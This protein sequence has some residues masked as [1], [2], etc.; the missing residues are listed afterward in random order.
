MN[1]EDPA[2]IISH[3]VTRAMRE[4]LDT[5]IVPILLKKGNEIR[6][7]GSGTCLRV[8]NKFFVITAGHVIEEVAS[9][10]RTMSLVGSGTPG[11]EITVVRR[12]GYTWDESSGV[13][14][15]Y[16]ELLGGKLT[17]LGK[18][19][20][21]VDDLEPNINHLQNDAISVWGYPAEFVRREQISERTALIVRPMHVQT[22][23][24]APDDWPSGKK[25][26]VHILLKYPQEG[27][28]RSGNP[29]P[30]P[31]APG[32]SGGSMWALGARNKD[33]WAPEKARMIGIQCSWHRRRRY[34]VGMQIQHCISKLVQDYPDL[35]EITRALREES[36]R[37]D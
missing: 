23:T 35:E 24:I 25:R 36:V 7:I 19:F 27:E 20:I 17:D 21:S 15:G 28:D 34:L 3:H 8:R 29:T 5:R 26:E 18:E 10:R 33:I 32:I 9:N 30:I 31:D 16:I 6:D 11:P 2:P 22:L 12:I 37:S 14:V 1:I 13:D 4:H